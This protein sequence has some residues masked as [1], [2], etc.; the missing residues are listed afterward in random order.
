MAG[1]P[2]GRYLVATVEDLYTG[3]LYERELFEAIAAIGIEATIVPGET[4]TLDLTV[5]EDAGGLAN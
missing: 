3:E 4:T 5:S 1:L 2:R